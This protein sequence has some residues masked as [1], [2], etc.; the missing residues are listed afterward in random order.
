MVRR[1]GKGEEASARNRETDGRGSRA[2]QWRRR[3]GGQAGWPTSARRTY[4]R[5]KMA[6]PEESPTMIP[7]S[8]EAAPIRSVNRSAAAFFRSRLQEFSPT[9]TPSSS[10]PRP[11]RAGPRSR[12]PWP[13]PAPRGEPTP[14]RRRPRH[15][16]PMA[17][18][19]RPLRPIGGGPP[20]AVHRQGA[21]HARGGK[22]RA[23]SG[24][25]GRG[26]W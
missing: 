3:A 22:G 11:P 1:G 18:R 17:R 26:A 16:G 13:P 21:G 8:D 14:T 10:C 20:R 23:G 15:P 5:R 2:R 9:H 12:S 6:A 4:A 7:E 19:P 24:G 25:G